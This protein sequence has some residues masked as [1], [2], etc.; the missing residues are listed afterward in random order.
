MAPYIY[1]QAVSDSGEIIVIHVVPE[2]VKKL[3]ETITPTPTKGSVDLRELRE[4]LRKYEKHPGWRKLLKLAT[5]HRE[6]G[7][8]VSISLEDNMVYYSSDLWGR[9]KSKTPWGTMRGLD[10]QLLLKVQDIHGKK[11]AEL[12]IIMQMYGGKIPIQDTLEILS[13]K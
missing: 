1:K 10:T 8:L 6:I 11:A 4:R 2:L 7:A 3:K 5:P 9:I 12:L 13:K